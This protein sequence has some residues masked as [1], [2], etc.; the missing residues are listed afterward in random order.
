VE[1]V[2]VTGRAYADIVYV[3]IYNFLHRR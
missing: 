3:P 1:R 2:V